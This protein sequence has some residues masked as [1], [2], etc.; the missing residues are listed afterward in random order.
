MYLYFI[1]A[2]LIGVVAGSVIAR[3]NDI[4]S[5]FRTD[6]PIKDKKVLQFFTVAVVVGT[7]AFVHIRANDTDVSWG[8]VLTLTLTILSFLGP[9]AFI[10]FANTIGSALA[11]RV[12]NNNAPKA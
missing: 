9:D 5:M 7:F 8:W 12:S 11:A 10:K 1:L 2:T 3:R 4:L 6:T